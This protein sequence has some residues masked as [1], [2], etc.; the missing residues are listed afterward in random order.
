M[1][2]I[3]S[4]ISRMTLPEK[5]GQLTMT[6]CG[7]AVTGP[8]IAGDSTAA[9]KSGDIGNLLNMVG[10]EN[11]RGMQRSGGQGIAAG[12]SAADRLDVIHGHRVLF[13][14]PLGRGGVIRSEVWE[15]TAREAARRLPPT[16]WP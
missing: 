6:A 5:L 16:G 10:A 12:D 8:V 3:E 13:P 9:I 14:I 2:R 1:S 15:A 4:L 11:V 7:Q